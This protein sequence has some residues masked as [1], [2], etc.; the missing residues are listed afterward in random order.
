LL[1]GA[2]ARRKT[3]RAI[4]A[5]GRWLGVFLATASL[6]AANWLVFI[7]AVANDRLIETSLGYYINPS[8]NVLLGQIV[9]AER[10][11]PWQWLAVCLAAIGVAVLTWH[12]GTLPWVSIALAGTFAVYGLIRKVVPVETIEGLAAETLIVLPFRLDYMAWL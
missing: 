12:L 1:L 7:W 8:F 6:L 9:L 4:F 11:R 5:S 10:R 2:T 3:L